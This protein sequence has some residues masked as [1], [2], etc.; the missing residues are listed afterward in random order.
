MS[1]RA[2]GLSVAALAAAAAVIAGGWALTAP[3]PLPADLGADRPPDPQAA[4]RGARLFAAGGCASCHA[5]PEAEGAARRV[6]SGGRRFETDFGTFVAPNISPHREAGIGAW[7]PAQFA[8]ALLRGVSPE[9]AHY[10]PSFPW[11]SYARLTPGDALDLL[12]HIRTLPESDARPPGH[13]LG[14]PWSLRAGIGAW[15]L[16][17]LRP[18]WVVDGNLSPQEERGRR[19][20]EGIGH[21]GE[22]HT[23]RDAFGGPDYDRWLAG[24]PNPDGEGDIPDITPSPG[25]LGDWSQ[26][27][28]AYY[29]ETGFTPSYDSVGGSMTA[30]VEELATLPAEDREAIAAYLKAVPPAR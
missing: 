28:I 1:R 27:D 14:F 24:G 11:S 17:Y 23:P 9:G 8:S 7:T 20:V 30:V 15:K 10:Y 29:L 21:C 26:G 3:R 19:L 4:A 16:L 12:A 2:R 6:L 22:C 18:D 13:E 25:G 5:D